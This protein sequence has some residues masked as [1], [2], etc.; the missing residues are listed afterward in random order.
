MVFLSVENG[1]VKINKKADGIVYEEKCS[2][3][4]TFKAEIFKEKIKCTRIY[5]KTPEVF[6]VK[7]GEPSLRKE[8]LADDFAR[9]FYDEDKALEWCYK[10]KHFTKRRF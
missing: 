2:E 8:N 10:K 9:F 4:Y 3:N 1:K 6:W 5:G 7:N